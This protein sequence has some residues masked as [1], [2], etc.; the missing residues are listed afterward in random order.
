MPA[1]NG[2]FCL[3]TEILV[4]TLIGIWHW[5]TS[6]PSTKRPCHPSPSPNGN[7]E[8]Y[9]IVSQLAFSYPR[10]GQS[11]RASNQARVYWGL[12]GL[13]TLT[14]GEVIFAT[15][16]MLKHQVFNSLPNL[17]RAYSRLRHQYRFW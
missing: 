17:N 6:R 3:F 5:P 1:D 15:V 13:S 4:G 7:G 8:L 12:A 10:E 2:L 14:D 9:G 16:S 11:P